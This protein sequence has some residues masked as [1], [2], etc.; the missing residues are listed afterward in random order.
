M[1]DIHSILCNLGLKLADV[2]CIAAMTSA[3]TVPNHRYVVVAYDP[4]S[5]L[6][7][8]RFFTDSEVHSPAYESS[9]HPGV[10]YICTARQMTAVEL[11]DKL[12]A[13]VAK[14]ED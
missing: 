13:A 11:A 8:F 9:L 3:F 2:M 14:S 7:D 4:T 10:V 5:K 12:D 6:L 1:K